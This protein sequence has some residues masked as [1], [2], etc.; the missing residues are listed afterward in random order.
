MIDGKRQSAALICNP[1]AGTVQAPEELADLLAARGLSVRSFIDENPAQAAE[2]AYGEGFRTLIAA[3]GDG[4]VR[5]V[6]SV[7]VQSGCTLGVL[8]AGTLNH[9]AAALGIPA[10][11]EQAADIIA[12]ANTALVDVAEVNGR[13]FVNNSSLGFYPAMV[14]LRKTEEK[15]GHSRWAATVRAA[16]LTLIRLPVLHVRLTAREARIERTTPLVFVG[17]NEY[18]MEGPNAGAR[19]SLRDGVLFV[20]IAHATTRLDVIQIALRALVGRLTDMDGFDA[21][22]TS[23]AVVESRRSPVRVSLDG[24]VTIMKSPLRYR[25]H[26]GALRV[27]VP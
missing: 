16:V 11:F 2:L 14:V 1:N 18:Q 7:A 15:R 12:A 9:F 22:S 21:F 19:Q 24:E 26:P 5:A 4:T 20:S 10:D 25:I 13:F 27:L 6:A 23:E 17:N 3:G 8:P